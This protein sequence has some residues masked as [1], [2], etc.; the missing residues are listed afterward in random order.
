[1]MF[2]G[3]IMPGFYKDAGYN[4]PLKNFAGKS[5]LTAQEVEDV[6]AYISTLKE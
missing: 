2:D 6:V 5:I 1:M 4:R 3:T